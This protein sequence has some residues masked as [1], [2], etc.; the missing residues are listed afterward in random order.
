MNRFIRK[1]LLGYGTY[2]MVY[3]GYD[4]V[5]NAK[6]ALKIIKLTEEEGMPNTALREISIMKSL[7]HRNVLNILDV[8]HTEMELTIVL[9]YIDTDLKKLLTGGKE[10]DRRSL[11]KQLVEGVAYL[12]SKQIVHRDLKPQNI[13]VD[14]EGCLKIADFGLAR[15]FEIKMPSYSS[16]VVTLWYRSPELLKGT[17]VY[18]FSI[19]IWSVGCIISEILTG[20]P[21]FPGSDKQDQLVNISKYLLLQGTNQ[22]EYLLKKHAHSDPSFVGLIFECLKEAEDE[23]ITAQEALEYLNRLE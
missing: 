9:S 14:A 15:S 8:L 16:E 17:K 11:I 20:S 19:D 21:L 22:M 3:E 10:I 12:H 5:N 18:G 7:F 1:D 6:V 23:R 2:S 13:L 4:I